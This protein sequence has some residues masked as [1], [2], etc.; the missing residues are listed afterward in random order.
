MLATVFH[1]RFECVIVR[2]ASVSFES[3]R[4]RILSA[5]ADESLISN[6]SFLEEKEEDEHTNATES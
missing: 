4:R 1:S 5:K 3:S 2:G 6:V